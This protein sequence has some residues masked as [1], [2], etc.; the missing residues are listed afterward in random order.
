MT[1]A[2]RS[3]TAAG[4]VVLV[5]TSIA[6]PSALRY[7]TVTVSESNGTSHM[8]VELTQLWRVEAFVWI[9]NWTQ[10]LLRSIIPVIILIVTGFAI[11][12]A[13]R[14]RPSMRV[15]DRKVAVRRRIAVM[16]VIVVVVFVVCIIPDAV[17]SAFYLGYTEADSYLVKAVRDGY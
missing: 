17:M 5:M 10:S 12:A 2:A 6:V 13:L 4:I 7:R 9:Y 1:S 16:L 14:R 8:D 11:V 3:R 15:D